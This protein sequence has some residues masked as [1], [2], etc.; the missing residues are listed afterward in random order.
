MKL[1]LISDIH[2]HVDHLRESLRFLQADGVDQIVM[3][4]DI[5]ETGHRIRPACELLAAARTV[6]VWGNHDYG[7][8]VDPTAEMSNKYGDQVIA[9][10]TSLKARLVIDDCY[11]A[12]IEPWL[13][14]E[15]LDD[16]W[17]F[18]GIPETAERRQQILA[19]QPQRI[20]FAG[21]YHQWLLVSSDRT[22]A[23]DG[24]GP[25]CLKDRRYFVVIDALTNGS[26]A[27]YDN[28]SGWLTPHRI[29]QS[30]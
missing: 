4:G 3:L 15:S 17:F 13:N 6:G 10:M 14:P 8:C 9:Y 1:G 30:L 5:Y 19:A 20:H 11:F 7:L 21:H 12:H 22:E 16:L 25:I 24:S 18:E 29:I 2:E 26:F 27:T 23:W 28:V